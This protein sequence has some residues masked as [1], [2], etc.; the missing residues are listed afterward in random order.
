MCDLLCDLLAVGYWAGQIPEQAGP[1]ATR[2]ETL[3][4]RV[5]HRILLKGARLCLSYGVPTGTDKEGSR[6]PGNIND[7]TFWF[8]VF[9][10]HLLYLNL[11][12]TDGI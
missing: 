6:E 9:M 3:L 4:N 7:A 1:H 2:L 10:L 12:L 11:P 5:L 8:F